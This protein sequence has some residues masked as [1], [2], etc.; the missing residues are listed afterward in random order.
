MSLGT[1][2]LSISK[3]QCCLWNQIVA[4]TLAYVVI[5]VSHI[6]LYFLA[7]WTVEDDVLGSGS[8]F[9]ES[10]DRNGI[11]NEMYMSGKAPM[12]LVDS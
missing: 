12:L 9:L 2:Y 1:K 11:W 5:Y 7:N 4:S 3:P 6:L 8:K 10:H